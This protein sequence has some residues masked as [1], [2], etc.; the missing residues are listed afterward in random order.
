MNLSRPDK[1]RISAQLL[2]SCV[3]FTLMLMTAPSCGGDRGLE[4][5]SDFAQGTEGW[6]AGSSDYPVSFESTMSITTGIA[7]LPAPLDQSRTGYHL[8]GNKFQR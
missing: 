5:T 4:F 1:P 3:L 2:L 8:A 7:T 6:V